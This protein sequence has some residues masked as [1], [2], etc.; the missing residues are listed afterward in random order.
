MASRDRGLLFTAHPFPDES[1]VGY[2]LRLTEV[3][4]Y[5]TLS[6]ILQ[7]AKIKDYVNS[8]FSFARHPLPDLSPLSYLTGIDKV[9]LASLMYAPVRLSKE[10]LVGDYSVFDSPMPHYVIRLSNPKVCPGCLN[11]FGYIRKIWELGIVTVCPIH[12]VKLLDTCPGCL[13]KV[14][15]GRNQI[16]ICRCGFDWRDP[17][18]LRVGDLELTVTRQVHWLCKLHYDHND[19]TCPLPANNPLK[20]LRLRDFTSALIFIASQYAAIIDT[21]GKHL[22][23]RRTNDE[24]HELLSKALL[25][26]TDWPTGFFSFIDFRCSKKRFTNSTREHEELKEQAQS[27]L[28]YTPITW[29]DLKETKPALFIQL[30]APQFS[31]MRSVFKEYMAVRRRESIVANA[32][33]NS[34]KY[35]QLASSQDSTATTEVEGHPPNNAVYISGNAAMKVLGIRLHSTALERLVLAGRLKAVVSR[36]RGKRVYL[37]ESTSVEHL[38]TELI[39]SL[40]LCELMVLLGLTANRIKELIKSKIF[41]PLRGPAVDGNSDWRFS[42]KEIESLLFVIKSKVY[43]PDCMGDSSTI[44]F[45]HVLRNLSKVGIEL[46]TFIHAILNDQVSPCGENGQK[47]FLGLLFSEREICSL[48]WAEVK[49]RAGNVL[50]VSEFAK[51]LDLR[52]GVVGFL[53]NKGI[54]RGEIKDNLKSFG[55]L[56]E[57]KELDAFNSSYLLPSKM[58]PKLKTNAGF[59]TRLLI[60]HG[61]KPVS[62]RTVDGGSTY[63]FE[64]SA[65]ESVNL[66]LLLARAKKQ[67]AIRIANAS[68]L[69][70]EAAADFFGI[71]HEELLDLIRRGIL[72]QRKHLQQNKHRYMFTSK[73]LNK[74]KNHM[75]E[76]KELVSTKVAA[77]M[78][79]ISQNWFLMKYVY[80]WRLKA[81]RREGRRGNYYFRKCDVL[82]LV[83]IT[84]EMIQTTYTSAEAAK[85]CGVNITCVYKWTVGGILKPVSGPTVDC[86][87]DNR[88]LREDVEKLHAKREAYKE[89]KRSEGGT[90]RYGWMGGQRPRR[91]RDVIGWRIDQLIDESRHGTSKQHISGR[92]I[93]KQLVDE[94]FK[95]SPTAVYDYL[96]DKQRSYYLS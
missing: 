16:S 49:R 54:I 17:M 83:K 92:K 66:K 73:T 78:L 13:K 87:V 89:E 69:D 3:N 40:R 76:F 96:N 91:V 31:F 34:W 93:Y 7:L 79:G 26:F 70:A 4:R 43:Q 63:I 24:I 59:L 60:S 18:P 44:T 15:W 38:K 62:G 19:S 72:K 33:L 52:V 84:P 37:I 51:E 22:F 42:A 29:K 8:G 80:S 6:W 81:V 74:Y 12:K 46:S 95:L 64:R 50:S 14:S 67:S 53:V 65:L 57:R 27:K 30:A 56:I 68:K 35:S 55:P 21:K 75:A 1:F 90:G 45:K 47:G 86:A 82:S 71:T 32:E 85:I 11:E 9:V 2:L 48:V 23:P 77:E 58:A 36:D 88:Y 10:R 20:D 28:Q 39:T 25:A 5:K 94:G 41:N 61:I